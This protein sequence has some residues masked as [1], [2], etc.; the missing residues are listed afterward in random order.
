MKEMCLQDAIEQFLT[1]A[2]FKLA[3]FDD[4]A[5]QPWTLLGR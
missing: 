3:S 2:F 4:R 1:P 5:R